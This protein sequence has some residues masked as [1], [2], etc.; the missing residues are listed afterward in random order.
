[1]YGTRHPLTHEFPEYSGEISKLKTNNA[2]FARL[3]SKYHQTDKKIYGYEQQMQPV[4]DNYMEQ[5][6]RWRVHLKDQ[7]Y[8]ILR[9]N[10]KEQ[11]T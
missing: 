3:L 1:M 10:G 11:A 5:L 4:A 2:T 9:R 6:K 7:L 8:N